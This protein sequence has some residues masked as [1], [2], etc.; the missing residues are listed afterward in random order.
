MIDP[1]KTHGAFT[2]NELM[3]SDVEG[4]KDF[5]SKLFGW[6]FET[7]KPGE[8]EYTLVRVAGQEMAGIMATP[9]EI[10]Q[11][12]PAW[13]AYVTVNDVDA[14]ARE[15]QALGGRV[16]VDPQDIPGVGRFCVILDPQG[17]AIAMITHAE[18]PM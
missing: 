13:G 12:P 16:V 15:A 6:E 3:T 7:V 8:V 2:W 9:A 11:K 17:A 10:S 14:S 18:K 1:M 4:A 5:Y